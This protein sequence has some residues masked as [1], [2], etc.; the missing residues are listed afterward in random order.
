MENKEVVPSEEIRRRQG[1]DRLENCW[2]GIHLIHKHIKTPI[3][4]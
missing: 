2:P 1:E 4:F 3:G